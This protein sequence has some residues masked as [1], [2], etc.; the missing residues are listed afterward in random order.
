MVR[1]TFPE[2]SRLIPSNLLHFQGFDF[3]ASRFTFGTHR[4][5]VV[6]VSNILT[7]IKD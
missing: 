2:I 5:F 7:G 4:I 3:D 6:L 1:A